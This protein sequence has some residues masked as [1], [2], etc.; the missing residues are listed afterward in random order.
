MSSENFQTMDE[1]WRFGRNWGGAIRATPRTP[2]SCD[3]PRASVSMRPLGL[4]AGRRS[5]QA[6]RALVS[7]ASIAE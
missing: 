3:G 6:R 4:L 5:L 7:L 2:R 1:S